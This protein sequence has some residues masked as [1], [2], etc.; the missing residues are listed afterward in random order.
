ME[1]LLERDVTIKLPPEPKGVV[2]ETDE[3]IALWIVEV[4]ISGRILTYELDQPIAGAHVQ[5]GG[6][7]V[8]VEE[9]GSDL[10]VPVGGMQDQ[11]IGRVEMTG[12]GAITRGQRPPRQRDRLA[13]QSNELRGHR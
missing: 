6:V 11:G 3:V 1:P 5:F 13:P 7:P 9:G 8:G 4:S 10:N 12:D 2:K